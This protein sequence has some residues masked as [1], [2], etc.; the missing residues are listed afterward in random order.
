M[1]A[2][3][4]TCQELVELV[5]SYFEGTLRSDERARFEAHLAVCRGCMNYV[6]Q[7]RQTIRLTGTLTTESI[8]AEEQNRL[9]GTFRDWKRG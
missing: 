8:P 2:Q 7:M 9:L 3:P 1:N 6:E 4:L 5:T